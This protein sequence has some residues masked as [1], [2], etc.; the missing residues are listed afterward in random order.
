[1]SNRLTDALNSAERKWGGRLYLSESGKTETFES[2]A[3]KVRVLAAYLCGSVFSGERVAIFS[4]NSIAWTIID[5]AVTAYVGIS[6]GFPK[7]WLADELEH[8]VGKHGVSVIFYSETLSHIVNEVRPHFPNV[9]FISIENE[10][11]GLIAAGEKMTAPIYNEKTDDEAAKIVFTSGS[12]A[13][14]KA[15]LLSIRNIFSGAQE[16]KKRAPL[17]EQDVC[18]LFLPLSHTYGAIYNFLYSLVFGYSVYF[19]ESIK[20]MAQEMARIHPTAFSAVPI[21]YTRFMQAADELHIPIKMLLG[22]KIRYLF[23]GGAKLPEQLRARY[24]SEGIELR[25]AYALSE[26]ASAFSIDYAGETDPDSVGTVFDNIDVKVIDPDEDGFG[27][28]V[29]RGENVFLGY[30]NDEQATKAAFTEDG[31]FKTGDIGAIVNGR[32]HLR[33][34]RDVML[35]LPNGENVSPKAVSQ[36]IMSAFPAVRSVKVYMRDDRLLCDVYTDDPST[37]PSCDDIFSVLPKYSRPSEIHFLSA[38]LLLK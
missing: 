21:V 34:R 38:S 12:T 22:G 17:G 14:P 37:A 29:V 19:A 20:T 9:R 6:V 25:N 24:A 32:V 35:T 15:V 30:D 18:Y 26:T 23:C 11:D 33:G 13:Y 28:L 5:I 31:Y 10:F 16:L 4:P 7:D 27:E 2:F 36:K 3:H 1:M 8:A